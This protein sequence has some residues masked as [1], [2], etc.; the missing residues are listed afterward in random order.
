MIE[1]VVKLVIAYLIGGIMGGDLLRRVLGGADLRSIG[2]GNVGTTN[3][4]RARGK[5][6]ALGVLAIDLGKGIVAALLIPHLPWPGDGASPWPLADVAYACGVAVA[7]GHCFPLFHRFRGGKGVAT[8]AGVFVVLLPWAFPWMLLG[9]IVVVLTTGYVALASLTSAAIGVLMV[10]VWG[11]E[12]LASAVGA[13]ALAMA[14]LV[15]VRHAS[16][17]KRLLNGTETRFDRLR[18]I[19][20]RMDRWRGQ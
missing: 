11:S 8:L 1:I 7:V 13:F 6:F 10:G 18:V 15:A 16:N 3:A 20:N 14:L 2:S 9:F 19:G 4:L 12:G 17:I 5:G